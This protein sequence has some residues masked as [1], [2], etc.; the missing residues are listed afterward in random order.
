MKLLYIA[1]TDNNAKG[2]N[3][4]ITS[5]VIALNAAGLPTE[6]LLV[7]ST[8]LTN[9]PGTINTTIVHI[10]YSGSNWNKSVYG[11]I[12]NHLLQKSGSYDYFYF[13]YP[14]ANRHL[15]ALVQKYPGRF[16]FE[17]NTKELPELGLF[18]KTFT[19]RDSAYA[20]KH[21]FFS[22]IILNASKIISE[23][24]YGARVLDQAKY[25][26]CATSEI[27][28]YE[29][30]RCRKYKTSVIGNGIEVEKTELKKTPAFSGNN[31]RMVM[32]CGHSNSWHGI[33]RLIEGL[34]LY[35]GEAKVELLIAG[36]VTP[37]IQKMISDYGHKINS[38]I[39]LVSSK[40]GDEL[41]QIINH[42]HLGVGSL[43]L[44]RIP[45]KQ[46]SV[47]KTREY[48]ARGLPFII[49]YEDEDITSY[50]EFSPLYLK[51]PANNYPVDIN[52]I[53]QFINNIYSID[54]HAMKLRN[55]A[56]KYL[57]MK[58]KMSHLSELIKSL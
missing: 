54:D 47:L 14:F 10:P 31:I 23:N 21:L 3:N 2:V 33:D 13:R 24:R 38:E 18:F 52:E 39:K 45:L 36:T 42:A 28:E 41:N 12:K 8:P 1:I 57:D 19:L 58:V 11:E 27:A 4:K 49:G 43:A 50:P 7:S 48:A 6:C 20:I 5:Q 26:I 29:K 32:L 55:L 40:Q 37:K 22:N 25:G 44:H 53:V 15:L 35:K 34:A 17:H 56:I 46:G 30:R 9:S 16:I 51:V